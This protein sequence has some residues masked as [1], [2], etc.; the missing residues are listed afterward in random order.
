MER[1]DFLKVAFGFAAGAAAFAS[2]AKAAPLSPQALL[3]EPPLGPDHEMQPA[4]ATQDDLDQ[5][6]VEEVRWGRHRRWGFRRHWHRRR[7]WG[8]RRRWHRRR[9][10]FHRRRHWGWHRRRHWGHRRHRWHR[11]FW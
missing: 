9:R 8:R 10:W 5:A 2:A 4:V 1:R 11:R 7:F 6:H 3:P